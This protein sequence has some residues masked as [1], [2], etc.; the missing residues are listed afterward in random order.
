MFF[1]YEIWIPFLSLDVTLTINIKKSV[2]AFLR[3]F[4]DQNENAFAC[5]IPFVDY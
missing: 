2:D 3:I 1:K 4:I 5:I